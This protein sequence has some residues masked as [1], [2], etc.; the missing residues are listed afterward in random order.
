MIPVDRDGEAEIVLP[1]TY[2][3]GTKG[4]AAIKSIPGVSDVRE[5]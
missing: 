2:A 4:R 3:I 1:Q 5:F